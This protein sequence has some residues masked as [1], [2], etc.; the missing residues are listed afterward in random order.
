MSSIHFE[1]TYN[2]S[3]L[4]R[5]I[6]Q[7]NRTVGQW[8]KSIQA[9]G[10]GVENTFRNVARAAEAYISLRFAIKLGSEIIKVRG[11]F[12][13][14]SIAFE[15]MLGSKAK[16]D[17]L[18]QEAIQFAAK[19]PFTLTDVATNI[20]QL[21]AMGIATED[22]MGTMKA[23]GDVAAGVSVPISRVAINYGQ[24]ATMGKL[25][26][27]E[28]R[29]FAMAG[30]PLID[31]LAKNLG[32]AKNEITEMVTAGQ[33]GFKD[34]EKAFQTMSGEGGKFYNLMEK[35]NLS[36][37]GQISNLTD[38]IQVML[39]S[40]GKSN[41]GLIYSGIAGV[42]KL[43]E[44]YQEILDVLK[45][46]A[47]T[48]GT[49]KAAVIA[50]AVAQ[51]LMLF[52]ENIQLVSMFRKELGLA[53]ATQQAFNLSAKANPYGLILA[54]ITAVVT[55]LTIFIRRTKDA[56]VA[57]T[58]Y[59]R[60]L[61]EEKEKL[62]ALFENIKKTEKGTDERTQAVKD[63]NAVLKDYN[64]SLTDE[65]GN[66]V[67]LKLA[68]KEAETAID[69]FVAKQAKA[70]EL[71]VAGELLTSE[72]LTQFQEAISGTFGNLG[73]Q[74]DAKDIV[75][76]QNFIKD[77]AKLI[78]ESLT[79]KPKG[80]V[81]TDEDVA[82]MEE[83]NQKLKETIGD[84]EALGKVQKY[85]FVNLR[86]FLIQS[87]RQLTE[88]RDRV[89]EIDTFYDALL[90]TG[91]KAKETTKTVKEQIN[92]T[93]KAISIAEKELK[94]LR[95]GSSTAT[96]QE[97]SDQE[98]KV[99]ELKSSLETLT[100]IRKKDL[101]DQKKTEEEIFEWNR[102]QLEVQKEISAVLSKR[103]SQR[104]EKE[105]K[106][107]WTDPKTGQV[108]TGNVKPDTIADTGKRM[109]T[110]IASGKDFIVVSQTIQGIWDSITLKMK[111]PGSWQN[112]SKG[113]GEL[114]NAFSG[115][116]DEASK[117][118][119]ELSNISASVESMLTGMAA[120]TL[121]PVQAF[122]SAVSIAAQLGKMI[123]N[124]TDSGMTFDDVLKQMNKDLAETQRLIDLSKRKGG[125]EEAYKAEVDALKEKRKLLEI[126]IKL[127]EAEVKSAEKIGFFGRLGAGISLKDK[128]K[129]LADLNILWDENENAIADADQKY[130][131]YLTSGITELDLAG[132]IADAF[133]EGK[134][135]VKDFADYTSEILRDAVL[136]AFKAAILGKQ[137]TKAQDYLAHALEDQTLTE[138]EIA[139]F[140]AT[141]GKA[142]KDAEVIWDQL[143]SGLPD[144]FGEDKA[145]KALGLT[146]SIQNLTEQTGGEL[147]GIMRKSSDDTRSIRDYTKMGINHLVNIEMNTF[148]TVTE[149]KNAVNRL[150]MIVANTKSSSSGRDLGV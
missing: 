90:D 82:K 114:S 138:T 11:E 117:F 98:T 77:N 45:V 115:L 104:I 4:I 150:D 63:A 149:L 91:E 51:K 58:E 16:A 67:D 26:G 37:T 42:G 68:Y 1:S 47:L 141:F 101:A 44:H 116:D 111:D 9:Q 110:L 15:T 62:K 144:L 88:Y 54:G 50:A 29:D 96:K 148:N 74:L 118:F 147:A 33:I 21:M 119:G 86:S 122:T 65:K 105:S 14:L 2:N 39:N 120:A 109:N 76:L 89:K 113:F 129:D 128:K 94:K 133:A 5:G 18:M 8:A 83:F 103:E 131:D 22:V 99:K 87:A 66:L 112:L 108:K 92:E 10:A 24:V 142:F 48:Y 145:A 19:T 55:A 61:T 95:E 60:S 56:Y 52:A 93:V 137:L 35:Q 36:V 70:R 80:Y 25:Q 53:T 32:K 49:Y 130:K 7:D 12:Q 73:K 139:R 97:I 38:K 6:E 28:L 146:G 41:E 46:L 59:N 136:E 84:S 69:Q 3:K 140:K 27:R 100:G 127:K 79:T 81:P 124:A 31:E 121:N 40:I 13:Q 125:A 71:A 107:T 64:I 143:T 75:K 20:K 34:V 30:I 17:Q 123:Q 78:N 85:D 102:L 72:V 43:V 23:L 57:G 106:V 132:K 135:S 126:N 134:T